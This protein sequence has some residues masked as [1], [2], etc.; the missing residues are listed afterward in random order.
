MKSPPPTPGDLRLHCLS[1]SAAI[2]EVDCCMQ[3][4]SDAAMSRLQAPALPLDIK[5]Y[6]ST[7]KASAT[8]SHSVLLGQD[9]SGRVNARAV[10]AR[11]HETLLS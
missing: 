11:A 3:G 2:G 1:V 6:Q 9:A 10:P 8:D 7:S 4:T 5:Y